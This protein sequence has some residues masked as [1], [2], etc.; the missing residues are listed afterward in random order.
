MRVHPFKI[1]LIINEIISL[2]KESVAFIL[3]FEV[4]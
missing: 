2:F 4:K 3:R 1:K